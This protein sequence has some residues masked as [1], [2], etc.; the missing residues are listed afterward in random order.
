MRLGLHYWNFSTP[1]H[2]S[3]LAPALAETARIA[4][5]AGVSAF[6]VMD[7]YF[8]MEFTT[9]AEEPMLEA[10]TTLGYVAAKTERM[11]L[12]RCRSAGRCGA[13]TTA[14]STAGTTSWPRR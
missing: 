14:G 1:A 12:R 9:S 3:E 10:Y 13:A 8:Q 2:P 5:Q 7:H 4:E 6:T 11:T